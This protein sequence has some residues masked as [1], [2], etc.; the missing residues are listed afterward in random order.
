MNQTRRTYTSAIQNE[1]L[2]THF[3]SLLETL[4]YVRSYIHSPTPMVTSLPHGIDFYL[5][6]SRNRRGYVSKARVVKRKLDLDFSRT[7]DLFARTD[8]AS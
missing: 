2:A 1:L 6:F 3:L 7:S 8:V 5:P 4:S